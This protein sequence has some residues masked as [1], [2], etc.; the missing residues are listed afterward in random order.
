[1]QQAGFRLRTYSCVMLRRV[2]HKLRMIGYYSASRPQTGWT[3]AM[4]IS[5]VASFFLAFPLTWACS[6]MVARSS[7]PISLAGQI[8]QGSDGS[9]SAVMTTGPMRS[10]S[11]G[12]VPIGNFILEVEDLA[13][14]WPLTT[15]V[16][17]QPAR[18]DLDLRTEPKPRPN[19][20]L[21]ADD[22]LRLAIVESLR[23]DNELE[24]MAAWGVVVNDNGDRATARKAKGLP[25]QHWLAWVIASG[26][27]WLMLTFGSAMLIQTA[28]IATLVVCGKREARRADLRAEGKCFTCGY[29]M[30]GLEFN[31]RC[32]ECGE[33][34]W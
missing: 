26:I 10:M 27:W 20:Q 16:S 5:L 31:E 11:F 14:G 34:V 13:H 24:A 25:Q 21:A 8:L 23:R 4:D 28:R 17:R 15:E 19:A 18:L 29:D 6:V 22:P 30:T 1:M 3:R 32:P 12:A 7:V 9:L 33:L 2:R